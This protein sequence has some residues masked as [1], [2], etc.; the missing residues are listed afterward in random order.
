VFKMDAPNAT[1]DWS[2]TIEIEREETS[3]GVHHAA[4]ASL[5]ALLAAALLM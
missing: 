1:C 3:A 4:S 2:Y 5:V